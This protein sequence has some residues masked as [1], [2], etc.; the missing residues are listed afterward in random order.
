MAEI[1]TRT[2]QK[3]RLSLLSE[4]KVTRNGR[5]DYEMTND[6][7]L[8]VREFLKEK[9]LI[10]IFDSGMI[11]IFTNIITLYL[12]AQTQKDALTMR[13]LED[14][15]NVG[16]SLLHYYR[17]KGNWDSIV[18]GIENLSRLNLKAIKGLERP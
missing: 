9:G 18:R 10:P 16:C 2:C 8:N 1:Y 5:R 3:Y 12:D 4:Q 14:N 17:G 6:I 15:I 7:P 11:P 13:L